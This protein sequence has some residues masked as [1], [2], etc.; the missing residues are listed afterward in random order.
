MTLHQLTLPSAGKSGRAWL[1]KAILPGLKDNMKIMTYLKLVSGRTPF[2]RDDAPTLQLGVD[3]LDLD[4]GMSDTQIMEAL[5]ERFPVGLNVASPTGTSV[6]LS[7]DPIQRVSAL[8]NLGADLI[9]LGE[10][11]CR[12]LRLASNPEAA[13]VVNTGKLL[14]AYRAVA[15]KLG[16]SKSRARVFGV[17]FGAS[18]KVNGSNLVGLKE[19]RINLNGRVAKR[20]AKKFRCSEH[21]LEGRYVYNLRHPMVVGFVAKIVGDDSVGLHTVMVN[22]MMWRRVTSGDLD[23]DTINMFPIFK[24]E[25][26]EG[27]DAELDAL[28]PEGDMN[29]QIFGIKAEDP[30][31]EMFG[32]VLD[33]LSADGMISKTKTWTLKGF[34]DAVEGAARAAT[35]W[36][37]TSY[38]I[39]EAGSILYGF[40]MGNLNAM[41][42][43]AWL[44]EH[45]GL[46][47]KKVSAATE[48]ALQ[49]WVRCVRTG[50]AMMGMFSNFRLMMEEVVKPL[51]TGTNMAHTILAGSELNRLMRNGLVEGTNYL[52][53]DFPYEDLYDLY[54]LGWLLGRRRLTAAMKHA[55][56][57][58]SDECQQVAE[59]YGFADSFLYQILRTVAIP[60]AAVEE[61]SGGAGS[62]DEEAEEE[63]TAQDLW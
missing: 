4:S 10:L 14:N 12:I 9:G 40:G 11:A 19:V 2:V 24:K 62:F 45:R 44:Y 54:C 43:G 5:K 47:G 49:A 52:N 55:K 58:A 53:P 26:A 63:E 34:E 57:V 28:I 48:A 30:S 31:M 17:R 46:A 50:D 37:G 18:C 25:D 15:G 35:W 27:L 6:W 60:L 22:K 7:A 16:M 59:A 38:R 20:L 51:P 13:A 61:L 3:H 23:G 36:T 21:E 39:L 32:E 56:V 1:D 33:N 41:L 42:L 29:S 8:D